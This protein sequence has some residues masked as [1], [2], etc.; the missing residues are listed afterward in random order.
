MHAGTG[1]GEVVDAPAC[2]AEVAVL[3]AKMRAANGPLMRFLTRMGGSIEDRMRLL[4]APLRESL[5][6]LTE[7]LLSDTYLAAAGI[8]A[9]P[10]VPRAGRRMHRAV[11]TLSGAAGGAAGLGSA[12]LELP[13]TVALIFGAMQKAAAEHG[14]DPASEEVRKICL[15][16]LGSGGPGAWDDGV[17]ASFVGARLSLSGTAL[18]AI[19]ARVAP[20]F[21]VVLGQKL[22]S[23]MVP[24]LGAAAGAGVNYVFM[25]HYQQMAQ[26]RFGL[27]RLAETHGE[28]AVVGAFRVAMARQVN[29]P[30]PAR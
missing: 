27:K 25:D 12:V 15:D 8:G 28:A 2:A 19:V 18:H 14:Y 5:G 23:Q 10:V 21:G 4:P 20:R 11:A 1:D 9:L 29:P 3:A 16:I 13:G 6:A 26:V 30:P 17:N 24:V 7:R 22:A